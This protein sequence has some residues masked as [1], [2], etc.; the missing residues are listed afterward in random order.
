MQVALVPSQ[1][2]AQTP[3]PLQ[4]LPDG[5]F[6][7]TTMHCPPEQVSQAPPQVTAL[8]CQVPVSSQVCGCVPEPHC[9]S[10]G[11]QVPAHA[12]AL[13]TY[14]HTEPLF[15]QLPPTSHN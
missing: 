9:R 10:P 4:A 6:P 12:P 5:G 3:V 14:G 8:F 13:Q 2:P 11:L 1:E 15:C 7:L